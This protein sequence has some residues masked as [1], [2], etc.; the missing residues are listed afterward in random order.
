M[1]NIINRFLLTGDNLCLRCIR[2]RLD[3]HIAIVDYSQKNK[4]KIQKFKET[5]DFRYIYRDELDKP[6]FQYDMAYVDFK[7]LPRR[8]V[9]DKILRD[10][11]FAIAINTSMTDISVELI[12]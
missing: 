6:C 9:S 7:D 5:V 11:A 12:F 1:N 2:N 8:A 10:K 4:I 3:L